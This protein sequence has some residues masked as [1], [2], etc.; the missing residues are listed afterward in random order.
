MMLTV[1]C[2]ALC[3][4]QWNKEKIEIKTINLS[5]VGDVAAPQSRV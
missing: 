1:C 4:V 2:L 3:A 5:I